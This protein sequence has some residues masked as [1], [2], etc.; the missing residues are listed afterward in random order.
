MPQQPADLVAGVTVLGNLAVDVINAGDPTPGGCASFSGVALEASGGHGR[1]VALAA[2][3]DRPLFTRLLDRFRGIL[4]DPARR[5]DELLP[6][7]LRRRRP[8]PD[9]GGGHR[10]GLG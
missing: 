3:K 2:D 10:T 8:P 4:R 6:A 1:I 9:V 7:G 5:S